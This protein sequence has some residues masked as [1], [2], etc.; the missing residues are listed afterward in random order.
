MLPDATIL[1]I[2]HRWAKILWRKGLDYDELVAVGYCAAKP[3]PHN[4]TNIGDAQINSWVKWMIIKFI[5]GDKKR[6]GYQ[7]DI[8]NELGKILAEKELLSYPPND[9]IIDIKEA[10]KDLSTDEAQLIYMRFWRGL[11]LMEIAKEFDKPFS[12][13]RDNVNRVLGLLK[14]KVLQ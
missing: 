1:P 10:I 4:Y 12:W 3:L 9:T 13:V 14:S 5:I 6:K 2:C 11:T 7:K 8:P